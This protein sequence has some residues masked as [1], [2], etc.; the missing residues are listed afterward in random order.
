MSKTET[1]GITFNF[2][3]PKMYPPRASVQTSL[4]VLKDSFEFRFS[5]QYVNFAMKIVAWKHGKRGVCWRW[6]HSAHWINQ[7]NLER[8]QSE[9]FWFR[10]LVNMML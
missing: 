1:A 9:S 7:F 10:G 3:K 5:I 4:H 6:D 8:K 2:A